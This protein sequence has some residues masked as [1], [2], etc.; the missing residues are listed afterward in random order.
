MG[1]STSIEMGNKKGC[2]KRK[3]ALK[4]TQTFLPLLFPPS[5][6]TREPGCVLQR[7]QKNKTI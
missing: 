7:T 3:I 1:V 2:L 6:L 4:N 5:L